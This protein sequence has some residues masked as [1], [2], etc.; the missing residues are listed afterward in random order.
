M[1]I[2]PELLIFSVEIPENYKAVS[3]VGKFGY[4]YVHSGVEGNTNGAVSI[5][6]NVHEINY[7]VP[8]NQ[9]NRYVNADIFGDLSEDQQSVG[10][11]FHGGDVGGITVSVEI[12]CE[13]TEQA[14][15]QWRNETFHTIITAYEDKLAEYQA[16]KE[17]EEAKGVSLR[18]ANPLFYRQIEQTVLRKNCI[19]YMIDQSPEA[20]AKTY[21]QQ[22]YSGDT[23][24]TYQVNSDQ[25]LAE[26]VAF[27][28]FIEQAFE[29]EIMSYKFYPFYW[30]NR[31]EWSELYQYENNDPLYRSFMQ[32]GLARVVVTVRPGFED[33]VMHYMA[34][35][36]V[37]NGGLLPVLEDPLYLAIVDELKQPKGVKEGLAWKTRVPTSLTILQADSIG[38]KVEKALP[39]T[40]EDVADFQEADQTP[41][42]TAIE[43][44]ESVFESL[45][46][47]AGQEADELPEP[48]VGEEDAIGELKPN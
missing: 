38:L 10:I 27:A 17:Q 46:V 47:G 44:D 6:A 8:N 7:G 31:Q 13:R 2:M 4:S 12:Q 18:E 9:K 42:V 19:S 20:T 1:L 26:Y 36:N 30:G 3:Y 41:C 34:T 11:G 40:C 43:N 45:E 24:E 37:W 39:C 23:L 15:E 25:K 16:Q 28:Q 32:A 21:G 29:W 22:L 35:G 33:A 14:F 5:G 48:G